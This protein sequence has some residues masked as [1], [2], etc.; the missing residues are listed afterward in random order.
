LAKAIPSAPRPSNSAAICSARASGSPAISWTMPSS[1][2]RGA[3]TTMP[4]RIISSAFASPISREPRQPLRAAAARKDADARLRQPD[5][6]DVP[7]D[8]P[9]V[10]GQGELETAA[11]A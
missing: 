11:H 6:G 7:A 8:D 1:N 10:A 3:S 4:R 2:A 9:E 5:G